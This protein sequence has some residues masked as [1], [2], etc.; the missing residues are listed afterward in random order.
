MCALAKR[1][2]LS[3]RHWKRDFALGFAKGS[4]NVTVCT[5]EESGD[6]RG[7]RRHV[8][9][10][11][12]QTASPQ[13]PAPAAGR[14]PAAPDV[15]RQSDATRAGS[16]CLDVCVSDGH[17]RRVECCVRVAGRSRKK[18]HGYARTTAEL[19]SE[20]PGGSWKQQSNFSESEDDNGRDFRR[21]RT[22]AFSAFDSLIRLFVGPVST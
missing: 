11:R 8:H 12:S 10:R 19:P 3:L 21:H 20:E 15:S 4:E 9:G 17:T 5:P 22:E 16:P 18:R 7:R 13:T 1:L 14:P 6:R 2:R